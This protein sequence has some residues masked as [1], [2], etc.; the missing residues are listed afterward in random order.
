MTPLNLQ[1][2]DLTDADSSDITTSVFTQLPLETLKALYFF[3]YA[4][5]LPNTCKHMFM[6]K[7]SEVPFKKIVT[8]VKMQS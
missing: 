1:S 4:V 8:A 2:S 5:V 3:T 7:I 6:C